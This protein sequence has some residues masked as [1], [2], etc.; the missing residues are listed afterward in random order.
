[1]D[2][3]ALKIVGFKS[4]ADPVEVPI[5]RGITG[6]VGPNGCGKSNLIEALRWAMGET[7]AKRMRADGMDD[8]IFGGTDKRMPRASAEV[9][10]SIDNSARKAPVEFNAET[11]LDVS[12]RISRGEGSVYK[13][14]GKA[15]RAKDV[16]VLFKDAGVGAGSS[17]LVSQGKVAAIINAKPTERRSI[18]EEAAGVAGLTSRR[19][20]AELRL[21]GTEQNLERAD[22]L[23]KNLNDQLGSLRRQARQA[24]RRREIDGMVRAAEAAVLLVRWS[25]VE[26][27]LSQGQSNFEINEEQVKQVMLAVKL[28]EDAL[29]KAEADAAPAMKAKADAETALA[30]AKARVES[31]KKEA[32]AAKSALS[33][34]M[35]GVER[36]RA[37]LARKKA[38][39][40]NAGEEYEDLKDQ[41]ALTIDER[42]YDKVLIEEANIAA[43]E[44][45]DQ[46]TEVSS[47]V[48]RLAEALAAARTEHAAAER[49]LNEIRQRKTVTDQ[50]LAEV[51][52]RLVDVKASLDVMPKTGEELE[53]ANEQISEAELMVVSSSDDYAIKLEKEAQSKT[54]HTVLSAQLASISA[55]LSVLISGR[56]EAETIVSRIKVQDGYEAAVAAAFGEGMNAALGSGELRWWQGSMVRSSNPSGTLPLADVLTVP[57]ELQ[58]VVSAIGVVGTD[59]EASKLA[60]RL[61]VGQ[62]IVTKD[63]SVWRWDGYRSVGISG[64][65]E[66]IRRSARISVLETQSEAL[67]AEVAAAKSTLEAATAAVRVSKLTVEQARQTSKTARERFE[68]IKRSQ[69][70]VEAKRRDLEAL[71]ISLS[72]S[73]EQLSI[74][75]EQDAEALIEADALLSALPN[76]H[77]DE[78]ALQNARSKQSLL[79]GVYEKA[80]EGLDKAKRDAEAHIL[81]V[82]NIEQQMRDFDKR[83]VVAREHIAELRQRLDEGELEL[84]TLAATEALGP[85]AEEEAS[86]VLEEAAIAHD[87]AV[88]ASIAAEEVLTASRVAVKEAEVKLGAQKEERAR[89]LAEM[90]GS[91]EAQQELIREISERLSCDPSELEQL[92]GLVVCD[93]LPELDVADGRLQRLIRERDTIGT[94]N[95]L[96]EEQLV[97]VEGRLGAANKVKEELREAVRRLRKAISEFEQESRERLTEAF[98][99]IDG[100]FRDLFTRLFGGGHAYLKL[101]ESDDILHAGLEIYACPPG[102]KLQTMSLMSGGEQALAALALVFAAFLIRPAPVCV[103]DEVDAPLDDSNVDLL[104]SLVADMAKDGTKFLMITHHSLTMA[105]CD[106]L[107]GVTM[108]ERGV[109]R[110]ASLDMDTAIKL[111]AD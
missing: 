70:A 18:L 57:P 67:T 32:Q 84:E 23:E 36:T 39:I 93:G 37:D 48:S 51:Q 33:S 97:E 105:K 111:I 25:A 90:K 82:Q 42:D 5:G 103:L 29:A 34:A 63:G 44:A 8:V 27:R 74:S 47:E 72:T 80:R 16:Q 65:D 54:D 40:G 30:L 107:Y 101:S 83:M 71:I 108:M 56:S 100:H 38:E 106:R 69:E 22:D 76:I 59:D 94:V 24:K 15:A 79:S 3:D 92:S 88:V 89:L 53:I 21:K 41:L 19:H 110:V 58:A 77:R 62:I 46:L 98:A 2:I 86:V 12:R 45:K 7:S 6:I 20:E 31:V 91:Q 28:V 64:A 61:G 99:L 10:I 55:E 11:R 78:Q 81:M 68:A 73:Q 85:Q 14:N 95:L 13:V 43:V 87:A 17:A 35:K 96:A 52:K 26:R 75:A 49:R 104:C 1:M 50:K 60:P 9:T 4:F 66:E 102:K 109:S